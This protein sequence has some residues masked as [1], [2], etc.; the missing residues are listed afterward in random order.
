MQLKLKHF[1]DNDHID[2]CGIYFII[3]D[4][5]GKQLWKSNWYG[6]R[7]LYDDDLI[8]ELRQEIDEGCQY[9]K[10]NCETSDDDYYNWKII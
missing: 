2:D 10:V 4:R 6:S 1:G 5:N 7:E 3:L 8:K 9:L